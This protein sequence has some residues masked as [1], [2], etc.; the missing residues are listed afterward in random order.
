MTPTPLFLPPLFFG[1]LWSMALI[2]RNLLRRLSER[3]LII[4]PAIRRSMYAV[5]LSA[6]VINMAPL[7]NAYADTPGAVVYKSL[8]E[9]KGASPMADDLVKVNY[10]G[11]LSDGSLFDSTYGRGEPVEFMLGNVI[12]CW[13]EGVQK[14]KPGGKARLICPPETAY[15]DQGAGVIPPNATLTFE[16]ELI[17]IRG[18]PDTTPAMQ[19]EINA[20]AQAE[21]DRQELEAE[22]IQ[23]EKELAQVKAEKKSEGAAKRTEIF[24]TLLN[25]L[26]TAATGAVAYQEARNGSGNKQAGLRAAADAISKQADPQ[27]DGG[28]TRSSLPKSGSAAI[29]RSSDGISGDPRYKNGVEGA[30]GLCSL[31]RFESPYRGEPFYGSKWYFEHN[32]READELQE[33]KD[34]SQANWWFLHY[35]SEKIDENSCALQYQAA[36]NIAVGSRLY[37]A[38]S[39]IWPASKLNLLKNSQTRNIAGNIWT[40][41]KHPSDG[42]YY[43]KATQ[44]N[45][46]QLFGPNKP[47][48]I[49][50]AHVDTK[51][52]SGAPIFAYEDTL[53][54][55]YAYKKALDN[56]SEDLLAI[57]G[58][59]HKDQNGYTILDKT[60]LK[61][62]YL[63]ELFECHKSEG[64]LFA[65]ENAIAILY[66]P[67]FNRESGEV[68]IIPV[69]EIPIKSVSGKK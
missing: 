26:G 19:E 38:Q 43:E 61:V 9:G 13:T 53:K 58:I 40:H 49:Y 50:L 30:S 57:F 35:G 56:P 10:H 44:C 17:G 62:G 48:N 42:Q 41:I 69:K 31:V 2:E 5:L 45:I 14:M 46:L 29:P 34:L 12:P 27:N 4:G 25:V 28:T 52:L 16:I 20:Y 36:L 8:R 51:E 65:R 23:K 18:R 3:R 7:S 24:G 67:E 22:K 55:L 15:G 21:K 54:Y 39:V 11:T 47:V 6:S 60:R 37:R 32:T 63:I 33:R 68:K 59:P 66:S 64:Y 1:L